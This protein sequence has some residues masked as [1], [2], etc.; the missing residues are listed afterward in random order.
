MT[1]VISLRVPEEVVEASD[2][3]MRWIYS[4]GYVANAKDRWYF[5]DF[6]NRCYVEQLERE[7]QEAGELL[8]E[9]NELL[10]VTRLAREWEEL[11]TVE[12]TK[13]TSIKIDK[14]FLESEAQSEWY[15]KR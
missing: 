9:A 2:K 1:K 12:L 10:R 8:N 4:L 11:P 13:S 5:R 14:F 7:L 6:A 15:D 3:I